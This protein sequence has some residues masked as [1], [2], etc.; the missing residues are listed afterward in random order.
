MTK[1]MSDLD[2]LKLGGAVLAAV[3]TVIGTFVAGKE[4]GESSKK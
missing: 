4:S 1:I 3:G 2:W